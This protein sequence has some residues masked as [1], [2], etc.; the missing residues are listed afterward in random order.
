[1]EQ[2][3]LCLPG[4]A[5]VL[6]KRSQLLSLLH[7]PDKDKEREKQPG[8]AHGEELGTSL[9]SRVLLPS[10]RISFGNRPPEKTGK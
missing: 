9:Q 2:K 1:M 7:P 3:L 4:E 6:E 8:N 5:E 10:G